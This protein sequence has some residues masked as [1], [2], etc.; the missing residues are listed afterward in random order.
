MGFFSGLGAKE[1]FSSLTAGHFVSMDGVQLCLVL[2]S[3]GSFI[4]EDGNG[5]DLAGIQVVGW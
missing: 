2:A 1:Y 3:T 4:V 5:V